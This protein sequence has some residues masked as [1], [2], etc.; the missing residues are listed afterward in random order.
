[1]T[2]ETKPRD[3]AGSSAPV[4]VPN[5]GGDTITLYESILDQVPDAGGDGIEGILE[6]LATATSADELN[7]PWRAGG[8]AKYVDVPVVVTAIEKSPSDFDGGLAYFLIV[9][10]AVRATGEKVV[11]TTGSLSS[12]AQLLRLWQLGAFPAVVIPRKAKKPTP[13]GYFPMHLEIVPA[14]S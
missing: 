6:Q 8:M 12:M 9:R 7:D 10:G 4:P 3:E 11:T 14:T 2:T 13:Q 5:I 1:M